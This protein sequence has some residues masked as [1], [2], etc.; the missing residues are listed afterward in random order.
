[1]PKPKKSKAT[2]AAVVVAQASVGAAAG[3]IAAPG[4]GAGTAAVVAA[5]A[6]VAPTL[7]QWAIEW[8]KDRTVRRV[9]LYADGYLAG[10]AHVDAEAVEAVLHAKSDEAFV[11]ELIIE[12]AR[13]I[14]E[15]LADSVVPPMGR[16]TRRY[17]AE[18]RKADAFFRG[19]RRVLT[20]LGEDEFRVLQDLVARVVSAP[21][22]DAAPWVK[23][24]VSPGSTGDR[25]VLQLSAK[26]TAIEAGTHLDGPPVHLGDVSQSVGTIF[27][28]LEVYGLA[29]R[30]LGM[31]IMLDF[32]NLRR[33]NDVCAPRPTRFDSSDV[34]G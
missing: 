19:M 28:L 9:Q 30:L 14:A 13:V 25:F 4:L 34:P 10:D 12:S 18:G 23:L 27:H 3:A 15:A 31:S 29:A 26:R 6:A 11:Q 33:M 17:Q 7:F 16:L 32:N 1:M 22:N 2:K 21:F 5:G 8:V 20:D 24:I